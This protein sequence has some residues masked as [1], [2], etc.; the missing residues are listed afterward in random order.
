MDTANGKQLR[1]E[2]VAAQA[3]GFLD[4]S[5]GGVVPP[6]QPSTTFARDRDYELASPNHLYGREKELQLLEDL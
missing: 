6:I 3:S 1:I 5:T 2:T 4:S